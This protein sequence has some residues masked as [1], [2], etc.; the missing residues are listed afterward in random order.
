MLWLTLISTPMMAVIQGMCARI[1]MVTGV[2]LAEVMRKRLPLALCYGLAVIVIVANTFN[3]GADIAG[4]S[5]S[6]YMVVPLPTDAWV[7]FFGI[8]RL[9]DL[10]FI[11]RDRPGVQ[12][13]YRNAVRL[14]HHR[15]YRSSALVSRSVALRHS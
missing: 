9:A 4:M 15:I 1:S 3:V 2:G 10:A 8:H 6:A 13:A 5:A 14:H 11:R 12:M 7:F